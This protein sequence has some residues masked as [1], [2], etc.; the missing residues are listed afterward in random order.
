MNI[1]DA[2]LVKC[3]FPKDIFA[4]KV[5]SATFWQT[6]RKSEGIEISKKTILLSPNDDESHS[7]LGVM[8]QEEGRLEEAELNDELYLTPENTENIK[9]ENS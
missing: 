5:L 4:W 8:L 3:E 6:G 2:K 7:N 1:N 9:S